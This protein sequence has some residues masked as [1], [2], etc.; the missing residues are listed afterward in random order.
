M[1]VEFNNS[2]GCTPEIPRTEESSHFGFHMKP[3]RGG[4]NGYEAIS[5]TRWLKFPLLLQFSSTVCGS[6]LDSTSASD[7]DSMVLMVLFTGG[8]VVSIGSIIPVFI[9]CS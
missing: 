7:V 6:D 9:R 8:S 3:P 1:A 2:D 4:A 5:F